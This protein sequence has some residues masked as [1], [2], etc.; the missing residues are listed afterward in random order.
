MSRDAADVLAGSSGKQ[1]LIGESTSV[2]RGEKTETV[3]LAVLRLKRFHIRE[4]QKS[5]PEVS[6]DMIRKVLSEMR[7][8]GKVECTGRGKVARWRLIEEWAAVNR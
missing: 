6:L 2:P 1:I 5:C 7:T 8:N 3:Q 4:L